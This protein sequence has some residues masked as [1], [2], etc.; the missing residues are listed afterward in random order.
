MVA[1]PTLGAKCLA[2]F[3]GTFFLV[4]TVGCNVLSGNAVWGGVAIGSVLMV[5]IYALGGISGA[6][7]NPAVSVTLALTKAMGGPG[8]CPKE[9]CTYIFCQ[10]LAGV[11]AV[12][13]YS[14]LYNSSFK[15]QP[16]PGFGWQEAGLCEMFYTCML[17][18]VVLNVA[19][20]KRSAPNEYYGL[21]IGFVVVAGAYGAGAVSGGAFNPAVACT[22]SVDW[23][24]VYALFEIIGAFLAAGLFKVVR[25]EDFNTEDNNQG[26]PSLQSELASEFLGTFVLVLTIGLN[27]LGKSPAGAYSIAASLMCMIYA[28]GHVSGAHFNPAVSLAIFASGQAREFTIDRFGFYILTQCVAGA[29][30]AGVYSMIHHGDSFALGPGDKFGWIETASAEFLFTFVLCYIVLGVAVSATTKS[31]VMFG[32]AI[33]ACITVGGNAIGSISG[34]SLNPAVSLAISAG[35]RFKDHDLAAF[36]VYSMVE[37]SA[38]AAAAGLFCVTH[39]VDAAKAREEDV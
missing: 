19:V 11:T 36:L 27:V 10:L 14:F 18:F 33:G 5:T 2:E 3:V 39:A 23:W 20:A 9:A 35:N 1:E 34:G 22:S 26:S 8:L 16:G 31:T 4:F 30:A 15:L 32:L 28:L 24:L 29:M 12:I 37:F 13:T 25:P 6:N 21:A 17:C 7:F 38:A